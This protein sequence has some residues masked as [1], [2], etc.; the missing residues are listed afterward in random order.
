VITA[1]GEAL[2]YDVL[3][4]PWVL[5]PQ[6]VVR[7]KGLPEALGQA[8]AIIIQ[9][10]TSTRPTSANAHLLRRSR[11]TQRGTALFSAHSCP[12]SKCG[13]A[14]Q[15]VMYLAM[16]SSRA[17]KQGGREPPGDLLCTGPGPSLSG[18]G[19]QRHGWSA[20]M[21]GA[22][23]ISPSAPQTLIEVPAPRN[24]LAIFEGQ[25]QKGKPPQQEGRST[26]TSCIVVRRL[27]GP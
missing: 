6:L 25:L 18:E 17:T 1:A 7:S 24:K 22:G 13:G 20:S 4:W 12:R 21:A 15:K 9:Q 14:P 26:S 10:L 8:T 19:L 23:A 2:S 3:V 27:S 11:Q 5:Q 16:T